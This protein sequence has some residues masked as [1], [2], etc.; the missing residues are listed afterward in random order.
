MTGRIIYIMG[1]SGAGKTTVGSLLSKEINIQ[2]FDADDFHSES[3]KKKMQAGQPLSDE[4][5]SEWLQ[6]IQLFAA[7]QTG[8]CIIACSALKQ[9]YRDVLNIGTDKI[10]WI[11]LQG[12]Y[13]EISGRL[14]KRAGHFMPVALL[15]SQ[16]ETL[17]IPANAFC[18]RI[19]QTPEAI[20]ELIVQYLNNG[21]SPK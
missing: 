9:Q 5:R 20:V 8:G 16:F 6:H 17:E 19:D 14:Q 3:N 21:H 18:V 10:T 4:D 11:F 2:F 15:Q 1:V 13:Q 7:Q 12:D